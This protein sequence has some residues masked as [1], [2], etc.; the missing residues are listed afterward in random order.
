MEDSGDALHIKVQLELE[1]VNE[2]INILIFIS[3]H[4]CT[5]FVAVST[6][7]VFLCFK[8]LAGVVF[9]FFVFKIGIYT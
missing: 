1:N 2:V 7:Y 6:K 4:F 9:L 5:Y 3:S 8:Y